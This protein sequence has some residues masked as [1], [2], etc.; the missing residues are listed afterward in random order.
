MVSIG[1]ADGHS[2]QRFD[3][4]F[5]PSAHTTRTFICE[6]KKTNFKFEQIYDLLYQIK[7]LKGS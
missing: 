4:L 6:A 3:M 1:S 5:G 7:D 2:N